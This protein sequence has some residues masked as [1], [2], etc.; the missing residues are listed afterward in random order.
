MK[1]ICLFTFIVVLVLLFTSCQVETRF[2]SKDIDNLLKN[3]SSEYDLIEKTKVTKYQ[4]GIN[5]YVYFT[6]GQDFSMDEEIY[7]KFKDFF[8]NT[9]IAENVAE[10]FGKSPS[11][12]PNYPIITVYFVDSQE[13]E[14]HDITTLG[15]NNRYDEWSAPY[16]YN[17]GFF[18][19]EKRASESVQEERKKKYSD[20]LSTIMNHHQTYVSII[21]NYASLKDEHVVLRV[22]FNTENQYYETTEA[23]WIDEYD[24][25]FNLVVDKIDWKYIMKSQNVKYIKIDSASNTYV[26]G[27]VREEDGIISSD[28]FL[29]D[30]E[31]CENDIE[32]KEGKR[33]KL[34]FNIE[35]P[36]EIISYI[37]KEVEM[38]E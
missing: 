38:I 16:Y 30:I 32:L 26:F 8:S 28:Y 11:I 9:D 25:D 18:V 12:Y 19:T 23:I 13:I 2:K 3:I 5:I 21:Y 22:T 34:L 35:E 29:L 6:S 27:N 10:K 7:D 31:K 17:K 36:N 14:S 24:Q 1:K 37:I 15:N 33:Y 4:G 20:I